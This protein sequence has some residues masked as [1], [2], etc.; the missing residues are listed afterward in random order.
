MPVRGDNQIP[1]YETG[2]IRRRIFKDTSYEKAVVRGDKG[3]TD[4]Y[5]LFIG[6]G[7]FKGGI[8]LSVHVLGVGVT[9]GIQH[10]IYSRLLQN[11]FGD[12]VH[13][14]LRKEFPRLVQSQG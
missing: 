13:I 8:F 14:I 1:G 5:R 4:S 12:L 9:Q 2:F 10:L 11:R 7:G 3:D 6:H